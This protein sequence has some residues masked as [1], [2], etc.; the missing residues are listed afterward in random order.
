MLN[1]GS[2]LAKLLRKH[3][4]TRSLPPIN[5]ENPLG[6]IQTQA[7]PSIADDTV[8]TFSPAAVRGDAA[9]TAEEQRH[10]A[11]ATKGVLPAIGDSA[12]GN[13]GENVHTKKAVLFGMDYTDNPQVRAKPGFLRLAVNCS[14]VTLPLIFLFSFI[15]SLFSRIGQ[16]FVGRKTIAA[17]LQRC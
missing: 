13:E 7:L 15:P 10:V 5:T 8:A 3:R 6:T 14:P 2:Y 9:T 12:V 4:M 16:L 17:P 1:E 11:A